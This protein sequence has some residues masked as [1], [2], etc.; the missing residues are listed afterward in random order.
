MI[1]TF[2]NDADYEMEIEGE[3][4]WVMRN[5]EIECELPTYEKEPFNIEVC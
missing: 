3:K 2:L 4:Y 1:V 5:K